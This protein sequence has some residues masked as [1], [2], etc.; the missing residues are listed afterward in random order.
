M[1]AMSMFPGYVTVSEAVTIIGR[2]KGQI[3]RYISGGLLRARSFG[4]QLVLD[5]GEVRNF[6]PPPRGNPTFRKQRSA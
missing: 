2:S 4:R 1:S 6:I 5:E 3:S